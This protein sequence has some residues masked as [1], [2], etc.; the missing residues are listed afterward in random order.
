MSDSVRMIFT[1]AETAERHCRQLD[2]AN[3]LG[4]LFK[5]IEFRAGEAM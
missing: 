1:L 2:A 5:G 3:R 4:R